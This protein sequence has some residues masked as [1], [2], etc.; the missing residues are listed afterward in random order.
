MK[1]TPLADVKHWRTSI[2]PAGGAATL[3]FDGACSP[4]PGP[5]GI[6]YTITEKLEEPGREP[7]VLVRVGAP[8]GQGTNNRAEYEALLAGLRHALRLGLWRLS[9]RSDSLLVVNQMKGYWY[10]R[11]QGL[12]KLLGEA[13]VLSTLFHSFDIDHISRTENEAADALSRQMVYEE[14]DLGPTE[15]VKGK[16]RALHGWQAAAILHWWHARGAQ[17]SYILARIFNNLVF[18]QN[19]EAIV[20]GASYRDAG[21]DGLPLYLWLHRK[22]ETPAPSY[23]SLTG[24]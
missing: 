6:G 20:T 14:P 1:R 15:M 13:K 17:S 18:H 8:V 12:R 10:A 21:F 9:V 11:D 2:L 24:G 23:S 5:M 3:H 19:V 4:N 22:R 7:R 16:L